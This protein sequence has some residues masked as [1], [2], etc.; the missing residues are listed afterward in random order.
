MEEAVA[1][2]VEEQ[3][4]VEQVKVARATMKK[5]ERPA[6]PPE[7][8]IIQTVFDSQIKRLFEEEEARKAAGL[9]AFKA[10]GNQ[11]QDAFR[12]MLE[13]KML[14]KFKEEMR[15]KELEELENRAKIAN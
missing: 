14:E 3:V 10:T 12:K 6:G 1:A 9:M 11:M 2:G 7:P 15:A 8:T 5:S 13:K 4:A